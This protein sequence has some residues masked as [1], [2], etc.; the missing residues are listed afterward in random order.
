M[1]EELSHR[2]REPVLTLHCGHMCSSMQSVI[3]IKIASATKHQDLVGS[4][5][6]DMA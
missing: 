4:L 6:A 5:L 3:L 2:I 1:V